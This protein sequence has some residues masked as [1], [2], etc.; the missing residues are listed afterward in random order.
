M[1]CEGLSP[2]PHTMRGELES[3]YRMKEV[4]SIVKA[5]TYCLKKYGSEKE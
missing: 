2:R 4:S 3:R 5:K 1:G